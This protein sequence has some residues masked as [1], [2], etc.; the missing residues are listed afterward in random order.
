MRGKQ[1]FAC[2]KKVNESPKKERE[3]DSYR[4]IKQQQQKT[5]PK[6]RKSA[7]KFST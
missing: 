1:I 2:E 6:H 7:E 3:R 4:E 5:K